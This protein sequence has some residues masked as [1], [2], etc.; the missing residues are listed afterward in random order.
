MNISVLEDTR[1]IHKNQLVLLYVN[2]KHLEIRFSKIPFI[3]NSTKTKYVGFFKGKFIYSNAH[4]CASHSTPPLPQ[5]T[6]HFHRSGKLPHAPSQ[7]IPVPPPSPDNH[8][9][10]SLHYRSVLSSTEFQ[11]NCIIQDVLLCACL[12]SL[13]IGMMFFR[14]SMLL[15]SRF[16]LFIAFRTYGYIIICLSIF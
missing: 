4:T 1:S 3:I 7:S 16:T 2:S 10:D 14:V 12:L 11:I 9:S 6:T 13:S 15:H 8:S 5:N